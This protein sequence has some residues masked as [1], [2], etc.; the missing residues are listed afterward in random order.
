MDEIERELSTRL[1]RRSEEVTATDDFAARIRRRVER[2]RRHRRVLLGA[3]P[4]AC[5]VVGAVTFAA[6][7]VAGTSSGTFATPRSSSSI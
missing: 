4:T 1:H 7:E 5:V 6:V 3:V 2:R